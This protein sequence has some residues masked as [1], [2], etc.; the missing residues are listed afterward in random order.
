MSYSEKLNQIKKD[1]TAEYSVNFRRLSEIEK[2]IIDARHLIELSTFNASEGYKLCKMMQDILKERR[3]VKDR[4]SELKIIESSMT[5]D[6]NNKLKSLNNRSRFYSFRSKSFGDIFGSNIKDENKIPSVLIKNKLI[7]S[8]SD[9]KQPKYKDYNRI[10]FISIE[11]GLELIHAP[12]HVEVSLSGYKIKSRSKRL[13]N[14]SNNINNFKKGLTPKYF[15]LEKHKNDTEQKVPHLNLYGENID[16]DVVM[17]T[18]DDIIT[19]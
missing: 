2:E 11:E 19:E 13:V 8:R 3:D 6:L 18:Q 14:M 1:V 17:M 10:K 15:S 16:G 7:N 12:A 5:D 4:L 9:F